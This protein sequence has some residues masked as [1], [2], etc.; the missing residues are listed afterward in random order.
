MSVGAKLARW[1]ATW[2]GCGLSKVAPGTVGSVGAVPVHLALGDASPGLRWSVVALLA[3]LGVW[4]AHRVAL[5]TKI[6]DPQIVVIDEVVGVLIAL[7]LVAGHGLPSELLSFVAFRA[8][9]IWK[10]GPI[11]LAEKAKPTGLGIMLDDVFAGA[12]AG[13]L[14][15]WVR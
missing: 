6:H 12:I 4:A 13:L 15:R 2:F 3:L 1:I 8:L 9:D 14:I 5:D 10:P 11:G 7:S